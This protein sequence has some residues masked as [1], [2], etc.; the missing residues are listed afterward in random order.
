MSTT[1]RQ[2]IQQS[3]SIIAGASVMATVPRLVFG[4]GG[5][6][7]SQPPTLV[8]VYLRGGSDPLS[9]IVPYHDPRYY[10]IRPTIGIPV[11]GDET[12]PGVLPIG[13]YFGLHPAMKPLMPIYEKGHLVPILN[14]GSPHNSRSHFDA[15]D[16]MERAAPGVK[17]VTTGW[18]NRYLEA[19]KGKDDSELRAVAPQPLLPRSLRGEYPVL[20]IPG[21]SANA[22]MKEFE[23]LY[24]TC[25]G[26]EKKHDANATDDPADETH[27]MIVGT[28]ASTIRRVREYQ[29][30][31]GGGPANGAEYPRSRFARQMQDIASVIKSNRGLEIA[32]VDYG[33]WD[34]HTAQGGAVGKFARMI[35]DV[36]ESLAAFH[37][38]LGD[39]MGKVLVLVMSE[40]GRTV[41]EN[42]NNGSD[43]GRAGFMLAMG[44]MVNGKGTK[45]GGD[46][47]GKWVGLQ[48]RA[49]ADGRDLAVTTDFRWVFDEVLQKLFRFDTA[50][51][52]SGRNDFFPGL[53]ARQDLGFLQQLGEA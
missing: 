49:L 45:G 12:T 34:H 11:R 38:D 51:A 22:T 7:A 9:A 5:D 3:G 21:Y 14:V 36:S 8:S 33:G 52:K 10:E 31:T 32:S 25:E 17:S 18:L 48:K 20:A 46:W 13:K 23:A 26:C 44:G 53:R 19:T 2:F 24:G 43:H 28:G 41:K 15:Q 40:F 4:E 39:R 16:F 42:G 29:S 35:G 37:T 1:R 47:Y 50:K 6:D 30:L 27:E